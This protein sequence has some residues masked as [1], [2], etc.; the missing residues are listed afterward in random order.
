MSDTMKS[1]ESQQDG[2]KKGDEIAAE[3]PKQMMLSWDSDVGMVG[4][5]A[6]KGLEEVGKE[7]EKRGAK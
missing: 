2:Q 1:A 5:H 4:P 6:E 3:G 7:Q